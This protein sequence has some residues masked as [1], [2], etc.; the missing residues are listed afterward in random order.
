MVGSPGHDKARGY[1]TERCQALGLVPYGD[2]LE[3]PFSTPT[4]R[5]TNL[6]GVRSGSDASLPPLLLAA[7][8]DSVIAAPCADDNGS[9]V[10]ILLSLAAELPQGALERDVIC[11]FFDAEEPPYF[12][13]P[14]MGSVRFVEDQMDGR[15]VH[16]A[17][18][19]DLMGHDVPVELLDAPFVGPLRSLFF[20]TGAES[21]P[22][23][24]DVL[25]QTGVPRP[26]RLAATRNENVGDMSDHHAFRLAG[27]PYLFFSCGRWQH[28]HEPTDTPDKLNYEKMAKMAA[29]LESLVP[30]LATTSL[31]REGNRSPEADTVAFEIES[32]KA[33]F[34]WR[35]PLLLR[36][37]GMKKPTSRADLDRIA[38][39]LMRLGI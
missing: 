30:R 20:V 18:V 15:G 5:G 34:G 7:H 11:A 12:L 32:L 16:A 6:V 14:S 22:A 25:R 17:V 35:F 10:A 19:L 29:Y 1:L 21:H 4:M 24:Q 38:G 23:L 36:L 27:H 33:A 2:D 9:A 31:P 8:Y 37:I 13:S 3:L 26:L 28:Y 39:Y